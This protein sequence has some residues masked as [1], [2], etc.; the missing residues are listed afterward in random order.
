MVPTTYIEIK[1]T[2]YR[3]KSNIYAMIHFIYR[4]IIIILLW[5]RLAL[6]NC[7]ITDSLLTVFYRVTL[8]S[9]KQH[10]TYNI[11]NIITNIE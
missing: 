11:P 5:L 8:R 1:T 4:R 7:I 2:N 6:L 9:L 3:F 10:N